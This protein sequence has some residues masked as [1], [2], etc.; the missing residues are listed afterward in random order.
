MTPLYP[1]VN[2]AARDDARTAM[3]YSVGQRNISEVDWMQK[4]IYYSG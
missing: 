1:L 2:G 3:L 4:F